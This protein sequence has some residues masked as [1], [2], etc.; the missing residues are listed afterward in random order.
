MSG[1]L[2]GKV[3][4]LRIMVGKCTDDPETGKVE[5]EQRKEDNV[6]LG[7]DHKD[8]HPEPQGQEYF[9]VELLCREVTPDLLNSLVHQ[10]VGGPISHCTKGGNALVRG[11]L[12]N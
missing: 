11:S 10:L 2:N 1:V 12:R 3:K 6:R 4:L 9:L 7:R 5:Q 8:Y